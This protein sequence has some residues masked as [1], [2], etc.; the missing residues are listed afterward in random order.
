M[1]ILQQQIGAL[2]C[3]SSKFSWTMRDTRSQAPFFVCSLLS[4][5][6]LLVAWCSHQLHSLAFITNDCCSPSCET[7]CASK[8]ERGTSLQDSEMHSLERLRN[9]HAETKKPQ[10]R[11]DSSQ[12]LKS[13]FLHAI[14][15]HHIFKHRATAHALCQK[16][17]DIGLPSGIGL[18]LEKRSLK[19]L[20]I[21]FLA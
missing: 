9:Q 16:G 10:D 21:T 15:D 1:N 17:K 20:L 4:R 3:F 14:P 5:L 6:G 11:L 18:W 2:P 19:L 13:E 12:Q 8:R 7:M